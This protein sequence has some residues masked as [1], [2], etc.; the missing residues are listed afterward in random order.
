MA[1]PM[2]RKN[3]WETLYREAEESA[4]RETI[5][6]KSP[7]LRIQKSPERQYTRINRAIIGSWT[8]KC[9]TISISP[10]RPFLP[11]HVGTNRPPLGVIVV[12]QQGEDSWWRRWESNPRPK[13]FG[14]SVYM[15][16]RFAFN[17]RQAMGT[18]KSNRSN[19]PR[20][21]SQRPPKETGSLNIPRN[22]RLSP[23]CG[24]NK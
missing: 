23:S 18:G 4:S 19:V 14:S 15:L 16:I 5:T 10:E 12:T 6:V 17:V 3:L 1:I 8:R 7:R 2:A 20:C 22:R 11:H 24:P 9:K 13:A 21:V